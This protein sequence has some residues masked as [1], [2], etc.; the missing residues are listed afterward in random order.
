MNKKVTLL[1]SITLIALF[2]CGCTSTAADIGYTPNVELTVDGEDV[3]VVTLLPQYGKNSLWTNWTADEGTS[4]YMLAVTN[5][6]D[7]VIRVNWEKSSISYGASSSLIFQEGQ[8]Y[9]ESNSPMTPMVVP[10]GGTLTKAIYSSDQPRYTSSFGWSMNV[11]PSLNTTVMICIEH[12]ES[13]SYYIFT[14]TPVSTVAETTT[15]PVDSTV[16]E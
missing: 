8:K 9:S 10:M 4:G 5:T 3:A 11:I 6:T 15:A 12:G 16:T 1:L 14:V 7:G 2:L 13:E